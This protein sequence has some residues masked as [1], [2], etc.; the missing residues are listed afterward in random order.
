MSDKE[1]AKDEAIVAMR[2][3]T[4][5]TSEAEPESDSEDEN[6]VYSKIPIDE[7]IESLKELFT[8][9]EHKTNELTDLKDK[10]V[11]LM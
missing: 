9:F 5:V 11:D 4:T 1:E 10:Y 3:V 6:E 8:Y 7:L 2:L